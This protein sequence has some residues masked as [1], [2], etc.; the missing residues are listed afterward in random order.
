MSMSK[1]ADDHK[2]NKRFLLTSAF[3]LILAFVSCR[4]YDENAPVINSVFINETSGNDLTATAGL[5]NNFR[6]MLSDNETLKQLKVK[7]STLSGVHPHESPNEDPHP[8]VLINQGVWDT[9]VVKNLEGAEA[10]ASMSM[11]LPDSVAG[12]WRLEVDVLDE[13]GNLVSGA[14]SFQIFNNSIP[15]VILSEVSPDPVDNGK[16]E[17]SVGDSITLDLSVFASE[18][19]SSV[20]YT[21]TRGSNTM[22][23]DFS[24]TGS[25]FEAADL[26]IDEFNESG[27]YTLIFKATTASG[28]YAEMYAQVMV[29]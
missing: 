15:V 17:M 27:S 10:E 6:F 12:G 16:F 23:H 29:E 1:T 24:P 5:Q 22:T 2:M 19:I 25:T 4:K 14:Y 28:K 11:L 20:M 7:I 8:F 21:V 9:L 18:T 26:V 3:L 13:S